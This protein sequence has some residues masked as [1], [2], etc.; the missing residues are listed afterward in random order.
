MKRRIINLRSLRAIAL[1]TSL[2]VFP[3]SAMAQRGNPGIKTDTKILYHNGPVMVGR[4]NVYLIWYGNWSGTTPGNDPATQLLVTDF[5]INLGSSSYF[6]INIDYTNAIGGR[7]SGELF[8]GGSVNDEYSHGPELNPLSIQ[9]IVTERIQANSFP[10]DTTGIYIVLGTA[11]ISANG[12]GFCSMNT[13]P[14]H[15]NATFQGVGVRYAF[16]G[17]PLRCPIP[18]APQFTLPDGTRRPTP[19]GN[20]AADTMVSEIAA[21]LSAIVTNPTGSSWFDR[22]GLENSTKCMNTFGETYTT[23]NGA[24]ANVK[25]PIRDWLLQQNWV[26]NTRKG[27]CALARPNP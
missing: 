19:N 10:L 23:A 12:T 5:L 18:E 27:F 7:P 21:V 4:T 24:R 8:Y 13:P 15:G 14:H 3:I 26:N 17:N 6:N 25:L 22:Y 20:F 9:E 2:I 1:A 16:I 11:D